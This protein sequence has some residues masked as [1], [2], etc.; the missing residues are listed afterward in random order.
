MGRRLQN[1]FSIGNDAN[2]LNAFSTKNANIRGAGSMCRHYLIEARSRDLL[3]HM[4]LDLAK[5]KSGD[6]EPL[7][8]VVSVDDQIWE[9][10]YV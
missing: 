1:E 5:K 10:C 6:H 4:H 8:V 7:P 3:M 9:C 2:E